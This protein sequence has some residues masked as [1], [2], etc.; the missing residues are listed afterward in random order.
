MTVAFRVV[1]VA[2]M[3]SFLA[4]GPCAPLVSAQPRSDVFKDTLKEDTPAPTRGELRLNETFYDVSAG[5][6]TAFLAP[7]RAITCGLGGGIG[8]LTLF[9]TLGTAYKFATSMVE[10]GCGGK[11]IVKGEDLM[12]D[13][14]P[15]VTPSDRR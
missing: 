1:A 11:W 6:A 12:P 8:L 14:P 5:V 10:E 2:L 4:A 15:I 9:L 13:R 3:V 7:G